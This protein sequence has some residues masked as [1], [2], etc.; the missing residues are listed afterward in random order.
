MSYFYVNNCIQSFKN[1]ILKRKLS[2]FFIHVHMNNIYI[3]IEM[4]LK[5]LPRVP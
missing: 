5:I 2:L 3:F 4:T 1:Y